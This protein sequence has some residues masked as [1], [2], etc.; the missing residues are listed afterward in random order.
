MYMKSL[1][2]SGV[3]LILAA[4]IQENAKAR[5]LST[6]EMMIEDLIQREIDNEVE[7]GFTLPYKPTL[8]SLSG[9][10]SADAIAPFTLLLHADEKYNFIAVCGENCDDVDLILKDEGGN[11]IKEDLDPSKTPIIS[12]SPEVDGV[13]KIIVTIPSCTSADKKCD[14]GMAVFCKDGE[15]CIS[16]RHG[17]DFEFKLPEE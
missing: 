14:F 15:Q 7:E 4:M 6:N 5:D 11:V 17:S 3:F 16:V 8:G 2:L 13:Y 1:I 9:S 12:F 10:H